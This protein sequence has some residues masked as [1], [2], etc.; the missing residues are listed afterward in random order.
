MKFT[1]PDVFS[2]LLEHVS[3]SLRMSVGMSVAEA[4]GLLRY[5]W[6]TLRLKAVIRRSA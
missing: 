1:Q 6:S 5:S 2:L 3:I 4:V